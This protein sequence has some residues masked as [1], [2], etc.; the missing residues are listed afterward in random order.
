MEW[1]QWTSFEATPGYDGPAVYQF[2]LVVEGHPVPIPRLLGT[3]QDGILVIGRT[4]SMSRRHWQSQN[5]R[6]CA[7]G[8]STMNL[9]YYW[10]R[11]TA[12]PQVFPGF[13]YEYRF[14]K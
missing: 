6:R 3:D 14:V 7:S 13:G 10:E 2:R 1:S 4:G 9:L 8:S 12:L 5:A 11:F